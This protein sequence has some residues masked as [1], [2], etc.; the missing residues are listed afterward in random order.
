MGSLDQLQSSG[1]SKQQAGAAEAVDAWQEDL[2][3]SATIA[4]SIKLE[5]PA[6][7]TDFSCIPTEGS[8]ADVS[9]GITQ[10]RQINHITRALEAKNLILPPTL[11]R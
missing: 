5:C 11:S 8:L 9:E 3:I 1:D 2:Q 10:R 7:E 4:I 6:G